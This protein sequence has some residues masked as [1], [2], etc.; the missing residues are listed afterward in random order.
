MRDFTEDDMPGWKIPLMRQE[1]DTHDF[2]S[3]GKI[4][5]NI[6]HILA[7]IEPEDTILDVGCYKGYLSRFLYQ[8][9]YHGIDIFPEHVE[10]AREA[11]PG[12]KFECADFRDLV[13]KWD[14]VICCR[15]LMHLPNYVECVKKLLKLRR[16]KLFLV[17]PIGRYDTAGQEQSGVYFRLFS[18]EMV[19]SIA[20][21]RVIAG[22]AYSTVVYD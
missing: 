19:E 16:K 13:G 10:Q 15:V 21:C 17:I 12:L 8:R 11:H 6:G 18:R 5:K 2:R 22:S 7:E 1:Q 20:P 4:L 9:N 14:V 3:A